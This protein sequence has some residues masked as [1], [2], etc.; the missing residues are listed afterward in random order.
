MRRR[1]YFRPRDASFW[2]WVECIATAVGFVIVIGAVL[3]GHT[4]D[5]YGR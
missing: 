5:F 4:L 2:S 1:Y 3:T